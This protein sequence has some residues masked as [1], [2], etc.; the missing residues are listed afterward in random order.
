M[1]AV[2]ILGMSV[3]FRWPRW[4]SSLLLGLDSPKADLAVVEGDLVCC[5][6]SF[7]TTNLLRWCV[8]AEMVSAAMA[9]TVSPAASLAG[10][11]PLVGGVME[12]GAAMSA[13]FG[14]RDWQERR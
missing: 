3:V 13:M 7:G 14:D 11:V 1:L 6:V 2:R 10:M 8:P 9:A 5:E 12:E 4:L